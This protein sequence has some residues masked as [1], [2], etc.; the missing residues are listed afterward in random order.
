MRSDKKLAIKLRKT[1]QTYGQL[2]QSLGVPKSTLSTWLKDV[3]LSEAAQSKI[4]SRVNSVV[5]EKLIA[6]NKEQTIK[7]EHRDIRLLARKEFNQFI[8]NPLFIAGISLYWGEGYKQGASEGKPKNIDFTNSDP[9]MVK[10]MALF[11]DKF[12]DVTRSQMSIQIMLHDPKG[13]E[14][15]INYWHELTRVPKQNFIKVCNVVSKTSSGKRKR[16]LKYGTI[17][18]RIYDVNKFFRLIG[19]IDA[20]KEKYN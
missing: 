18:L 20:L 19:W 3:Q 2:S 14:K 17:H 13:S 12:L 11:F 15:A 4:Q 7:A 1:G 8:K 5:I 9:E 10:L 16:I 6:R